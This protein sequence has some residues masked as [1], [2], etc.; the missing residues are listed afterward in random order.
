MPQ[1][2]ILGSIHYIVQLLIANFSWWVKNLKIFLLWNDES[3]TES[4]IYDFKQL[5]KAVISGRADIVMQYLQEFDIN[6]NDK[7]DFGLTLLMKSCYHGSVEVEE[8]LLAWGADILVKDEYGFTAFDMM[9]VEADIV[10]RMR[11]FVAELDK[12]MIELVGDVLV[13]SV[14]PA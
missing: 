1:D 12:D 9:S 7:D 14:I 6:I 10:M 5:E 8:L 13:S 2:I 4:L 3:A 11:Y